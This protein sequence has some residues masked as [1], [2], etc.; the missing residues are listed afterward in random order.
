MKKE[1]KIKIQFFKYSLFFL[2]YLVIG[3]LDAQAQYFYKK[4]YEGSASDKMTIVWIPS[5]FT[6]EQKNIFDEKVDSVTKNMWD[7]N[8]FKD[9]KEYFNIYKLENDDGSEKIPIWDLDRKKKTP[10]ELKLLIK[11]LPNNWGDCNFLNDPICKVFPSVLINELSVA[12]GAAKGYFYIGRTALEYEYPHEWGH[13][14]FADILCD[15]YENGPGASGAHWCRNLDDIPSTRKWIPFIQSSAHEGGNHRKRGLFRPSKSS[16]MRD[17]KNDSDFDALGY[18]AMNKGLE[19]RYSRM[20]SKPPSIKC[21]IKNG[22]ILSDDVTVICDAQDE[23]GIEM[24]VFYIAKSGEFHQ[25]FG[26]DETSPYQANLK[27]SELEEGKYYLRCVAWDKNWNFSQDNPLFK[28]AHREAP[29]ALNIPLT[30]KEVAGVDRLNDIVSSGVPFPQGLIHDPDKLA[31]YNPDG[32]QIP[33]QFK[34]LERWIEDGQDKSIKWLLVTF[35]GNVAANS[36]KIYYLRHSKKF[37]SETP[38]AIN[39]T[40]SNFIIGNF[41]IKK[42][43][44]HPFK[45]ILTDPQGNKYFSDQLST[46]KWEIVENGPVRACIKAENSCDEDPFGFMLWLYFYSGTDRCDM[47]VVL[48]NTPRKPKGPFYFKDF[49]VVWDTHGTDYTIGG[50]KGQILSGDLPEGDVVYLYQDSSGTDRWDKLSEHSVKK[51]MTG[52]YVAPM[53][54]IKEEGLPS[55]R[56]YEIRKN[57]IQILKGNKAI[58]WATLNNTS[59]ALQHFWQ[60]FP[61]AIEI[62][63]NQI[64]LRLWPKYWKGHGGIHWLDDLQRKSHD[65]QF[66]LTPMNENQALAFNY[67]LLIHCGLEWYRE[68]GALG[69]ISKKNN[70]KYKANAKNVL[71]SEY[72]WVTYGG[73]FVDR[74]RRRYHEYKM[75]DFIL[76]SDPF[77]AYKLLLAM[78]HTA[79]ITPFWMDEYS[80]PNDKGLLRAIAYAR[81]LRDH[82]K[83]TPG[84]DHHGYMPW[85]Q[86]HWMASELFDGWRLFGDPLSYDAIQ[87]SGIFLLHWIDFR[88][89]NPIKSSRLDALPQ[90]VLAEIYRVTN[91]PLVKQALKA[92]L[93]IIWEHINKERGYYAPYVTNKMP[94]GY[95][96]SFMLGYLAEG[97]YENYKIIH[98]ERA[99]DMITGMTDYVIRESY[100][101]PCYAVLYETPI[102][103]D[104]LKNKREEAKISPTAVCDC[105]SFEKEN[106]K[107]KDCYRFRDQR[108]LSLAA[109]SYILTGDPEYKKIFDSVIE[110]GNKKGRRERH[111]HVWPPIFDEIIEINKKNEIQ[112]ARVDDLE[113]LRLGSNKILLKWTAPK[114]ANQYQIKY[115]EKLIQE[116][117]YNNKNNKS[118]TYWWAA[119]NVQG[120]SPPKRE[121]TKEELILKGI[122]KGKKYFYIRSYDINNNLSP[123]SNYAE[124]DI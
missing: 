84:S 39:E 19:K 44:S 49:S 15:E 65:I 90:N 40:E 121:G 36:Q 28:I 108:I 103:L 16:I 33:A 27:I 2:V 41:N 18:E 52:A 105:S 35:L 116:K 80:Y 72:G 29:T 12:G 58:G 98:D 21:S 22:D 107:K 86:Q 112:P 93:N 122:G 94:E 61:K 31:V 67:P 63:K 82:G 102:N 5:G 59:I 53:S 100:I 45:L 92:Y 117:N 47:T 113:A 110:G 71:K 101:N 76:T 124:I 34:V 83:Y 46:I 20:E 115:S 96:K 62:N 64:A 30:I 97:L 26:F 1:F 77:Y 66:N 73:N 56:G 60:Q 55:F 7:V 70:S 32:V 109:L 14:G 11:N 89:K 8:W 118:R 23:S 111:F 3:T 9:H 81:P 88:R 43:L 75:N 51:K 37:L 95:E 104:L 25:S 85:N 50:E 87:K 106:A 119:E 38:V 48:K 42:D 78:K 74:I 54:K 69:Y 24:V 120:E 57:G 10:K 68:S 123:L 91:D 17:P 4:I 79:S 99:L 114:A 6:N 13:D